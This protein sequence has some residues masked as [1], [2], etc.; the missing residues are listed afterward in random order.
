MRRWPERGNLVVFA[1]VVL[2]GGCLLGLQVAD[3]GPL[4]WSRAGAVSVTAA[5]A[6]ALAARTGGRPVAFGVLAL[7]IGGLAVWLERPW[8][9]TGAAVLSA[10]VAG[11]LGVMVT[12]PARRFLHAAREVLIALAVS[13]V[14]ALAAVGF[15]PTVSQPRWEYVT[16]GLALALALV[17]VY[18]LG[19]GLHGLGRRGVLVIVVGSLGLAVSLAYAELL[20]R[21]GSPVVARSI[22]DVV[23]WSYAELGAFPRPMQAVLGIPA[24]VWGCHQRARRRQGWW[25]CA[26]GVAATVPPAHLLTD[27]RFSLAE[28]AL[29]ELYSL[30]VGL[31][32]GYL[33]IRVDL[34]LTGSRS[35]GAR[36]A[37]V[38]GA[39][40]PEPPRTA[41]L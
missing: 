39:L 19:A 30:L 1:L 25:A 37:E 8:L 28:I 38:A 17:L 6:W 21:Y 11:V 32:L 12:V 5:Y 27:P 18:R 13:A 34:L 24:L 2:V 31:A 33:L 22:G 14:G 29:V 23:R 40:R 36:R 41:S 16:L 15:G 7:V 10:V 26:F 9:S 4:W 35:R 3:I 20:R